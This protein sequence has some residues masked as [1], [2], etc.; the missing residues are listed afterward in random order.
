MATLC[1]FGTQAGR[2][3]VRTTF[4][5]SITASPL[6]STR[7]AHAS[8]WNAVPDAVWSQVL[9]LIWDSCCLFQNKNPQFRGFLE[10]MM[11]LEPTTFCMAKVGR[12]S[13]PFAR[14]RRN[15]LFA[16]AS[17]WPSERQRTRTNAEC[18]HCSHCDRC[19]VQLA[20][21]GS[22]TPALATAAD[23]RLGRDLSSGGQDFPANP[24][25]RIYEPTR[26]R[27]VRSAPSGVEP[28]AA[29]DLPF[30]F[31]GSL[32]A[33]SIDAAH[34]G[35][36]PPGARITDRGRRGRRSTLGAAIQN[37]EQPAADSHLAEG[38]NRSGGDEHLRCLER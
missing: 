5:G 36:R 34:Q 18:G 17:D 3:F 32:E 1:V 24:R 6:P 9:G 22:A 15:L 26:C 31:P 7:C 16:A 23:F 35:F 14:V 20:W 29:P 2:L 21:P 10:R 4:Y 27:G 38:P 19:H 33:R 37:R 13:R 12:R 8:R 30:R 11:G 28:S 25:D